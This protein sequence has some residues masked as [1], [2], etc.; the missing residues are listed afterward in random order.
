MEKWDPP[1]KT[2]RL[3]LLFSIYFYHKIHHMLFGRPADFKS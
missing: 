2:I 1:K 3:P